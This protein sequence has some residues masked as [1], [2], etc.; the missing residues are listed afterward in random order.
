MPTAT[1]THTHTH[2]HIRACRLF[3]E[4]QRQWER[5][6]TGARRHAPVQCW[7]TDRSMLAICM[8]QIARAAAPTA[9]NRLHDQQIADEQF[10]QSATRSLLEPLWFA[11]DMAIQ[12]CFYYV[13]TSIGRDVI[14]KMMGGICLSVSCLELTRER[15]GL[16]SLKLA[17]WKPITRATREPI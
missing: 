12:S 6:C 7:S 14:T 3:A 4:R 10:A 5:E 13:P 9:P 8:I 11:C 15:K 16:G 2:N 17:R 1:H